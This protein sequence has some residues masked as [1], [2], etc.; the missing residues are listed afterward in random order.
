MRERLAPILYGIYFIGDA[1]TFIF[2]TFL[3]DYRYTWWNWVIAVPINFFLA[4]IWPIYWV[5]LR[6]LFSS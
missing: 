5:V 1:A 3:D 4:Q 2:L 6:P